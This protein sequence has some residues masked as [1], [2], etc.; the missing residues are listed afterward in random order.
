MND[1]TKTPGA[2][3]IVPSDELHRIAD[4]MKFNCPNLAVE[5]E[6]IVAASVDQP[7]AVGGDIPRYWVHWNDQLLVKTPDVD[8]DTVC[9]WPDVAPLVADRDKWAPSRLTGGFSF[10]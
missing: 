6:Q 8:E 1:K 9:K 7:P 2:M 5:L 4:R 10:V 3:V